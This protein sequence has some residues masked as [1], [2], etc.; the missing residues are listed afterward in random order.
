RAGLRGRRN[1]PLCRAL[2]K[3]SES[4]SLPHGPPFLRTLSDQVRRGAPNSVRYR[5]P[6]SYT[7]GSQTPSLTVGHRLVRPRQRQVL[8]L[9]ARLVDQLFEIRLFRPNVF[10]L[11]RTGNFAFDGY[12][13]GIIEL[14][15][16]AGILW[17]VDASLPN[18]DC[19]A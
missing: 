4:S 17:K 8:I 19:L 6:S 11:L 9:C 5:C 15:K 13:P 14:F 10:K 18:V 12:G 7:S 2:T 3:A 1:W 16:M